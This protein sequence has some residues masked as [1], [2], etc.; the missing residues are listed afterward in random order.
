MP[1][2]FIVLNAGDEPVIAFS[3]REAAE[4]YCEEVSD[5]TIKIMELHKSFNLSLV[6][7]ADFEGIESVGRASS[8]AAVA[9]VEEDEEFI[10]DDEELEEDEDEELTGLDFGG[11]S[12]EDDPYGD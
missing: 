7:N 12:G 10:A 9:D 1:K 11:D 3:N 4:E 6:D 2:V 8:K 5:T